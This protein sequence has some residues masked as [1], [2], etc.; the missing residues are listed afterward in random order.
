MPDTS[1]KMLQGL[2]MDLPETG[3]FRLAQMDTWKQLPADASLAKP[4]SLF[5]RVDVPR[6]QGR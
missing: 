5:P 3:F 6:K 1:R 4:D 2:M